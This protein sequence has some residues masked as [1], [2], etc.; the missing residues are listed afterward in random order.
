[1]GRW[2]GHRAVVVATAMLLVA[3]CGAG[4]EGEVDGGT[5]DA[6]SLIHI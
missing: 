4:P 5:G 3:S 1:M 6:L 2:L